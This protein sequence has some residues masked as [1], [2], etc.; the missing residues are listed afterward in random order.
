MA[1]QKTIT[2][3][4]IDGVLTKEV[5]G[6]GDNIYLSRTPRE[7]NIEKINKLFDLGYKIV[8]YSSRYKEDEWPTRRWLDMHGIK[9]HSLIL[10]K[11]QYNVF[12]D[13]KTIPDMVD[14][15]D[16]ILNYNFHNSCWRFTKGNIT[17]DER[18]PCFF[19]GYSISLEVP[20]CPHCG[21]MPCPNCGK[22]LC[23]IPILTY[24]TLIR[25]H[26]KYCCNLPEFNGKICLD[27][28]VDNTL[29]QNC[30]VTL[31]HCKHLEGI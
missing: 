23:N 27:G 22:C 6:W 17:P 5:E 10:G 28:F 30:E 12:I 2:Y 29:I 31:L 21:I 4:D 15:L 19:C 24:I 25:I 9:Y 3:V 8:L 14:N 13:D 26:K 20:D 11:P 1:N 18:H 16:E 7:K